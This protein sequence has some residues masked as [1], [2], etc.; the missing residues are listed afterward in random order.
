MNALLLR[1]VSWLSSTTRCAVHIDVSL[2]PFGDFQGHQWLHDENMNTDE[3]TVCSDCSRL[4]CW[5]KASTFSGER[6]PWFSFNTIPS[7]GSSG[8]AKPR[9]QGSD[10]ARDA[11]SERSCAGAMAGQMLLVKIGRIGR[12]VCFSQS[13]DGS[14]RGS[15]WTVGGPQ[16]RWEPG[17]AG[18][19]GKVGLCM[20]MLTKTVTVLEMGVN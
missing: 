15:F 11:T 1:G 6:F 14:V 17:T 9:P 13:S 16:E 20:L 12:L 7:Q 18:F 5:S 3:E 2:H 10:R 8:L 19:G 4:G